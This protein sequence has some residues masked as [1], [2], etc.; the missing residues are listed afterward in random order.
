MIHLVEVF[1]VDDYRRSAFCS[2]SYVDNRQ[3]TDDLKRQVLGII[4]GCV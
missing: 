4:S 2:I 1:C 3:I